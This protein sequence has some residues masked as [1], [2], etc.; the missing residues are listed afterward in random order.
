MLIICKSIVEVGKELFDQCRG[1]KRDYI[2][3]VSNIFQ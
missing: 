3:V 1:H 2:K